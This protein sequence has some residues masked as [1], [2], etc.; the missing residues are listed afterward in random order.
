MTE[1]WYTSYNYEKTDEGSDYGL[2]HCFDESNT[3]RFWESHL[4]SNYKKDWTLD[5]KLHKSISPHFEYCA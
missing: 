4:V 2:I 1:I 3:K 5:E